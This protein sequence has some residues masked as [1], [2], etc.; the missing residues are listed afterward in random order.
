MTGR[1]HERAIMNSLIKEKSAELLAILGRRRVG[2]TYL[3]SKHYKDNLVF[4]FTGTQDAD[5]ENQLEKFR[6]K[7]TQS[8]SREI[9][10]IKNWAQAFNHLSAYLK[11]SRKKKKPVVFFDEFPWIASR[12]SNFLQEFSYWWNDWASKQNIVVV[13]C[14]SA[15]SWMIDKVVNH[16]GGLHNRLTSMINLRPFT[17]A[18]V[19]LL[20]TS[21]SPRDATLS[22]MPSSA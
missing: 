22:R 19:C 5:T 6:N 15:A 1:Q 9:E 13:I 11:R 12:R 8:T 20:Y 18:E 3:V 17:L 4:A 10:V 7:L 21:P 16:K 2:K 14:G